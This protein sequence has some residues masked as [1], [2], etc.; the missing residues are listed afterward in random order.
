[1]NKNDEKKAKDEAFKEVCDLIY[2]YFKYEEALSKGDVL[3]H[4]G[5]KSVAALEMLDILGEHENEI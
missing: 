5:R 4:H 3:S 1:M 2:R